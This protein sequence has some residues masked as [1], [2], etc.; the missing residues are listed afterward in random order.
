M[1]LSPLVFTQGLHGGESSGTG[2]CIRIPVLVNLLVFSLCLTILFQGMRAI[3]F[4]GGFV[5]SGGPYAIAH[6]A[7]DWVWIFPVSVILMVIT[8]LIGI[9]SIRNNGG[10][11][12]MA[13][14]WSAVFLSL[15]WNFLNFG[16][17]LPTD[18]GLIPGWLICAACFIPM[19]AIPL[20]IILASF[21]RHLKNNR[22]AGYPFSWDSFLVQ[23]LC[24]AAGVYLGIKIF[25]AVT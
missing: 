24:A 9:G 21:F 22:S 19:G 2:K 3:M 17:G 14:S 8:M 11:N 1:K 18:S 13:L 20:W 4:L 16:L 10:P 23:L 7:P 15:G 12:F 5:A 25:H 6:P